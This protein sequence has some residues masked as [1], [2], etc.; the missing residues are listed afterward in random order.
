VK[1]TSKAKN[2]WQTRGYN[3]TDTENPRDF[4]PTPAHGTMALLRRETFSFSILEPASGNGAM[5]KVFRWWGH[6][7]EEA[8]LDR[9]EDFLRR[10]ES[11][12]SVVTNP[13]YGKGYAEKFVRQALKLA[14]LKV[15]MLLPF[16]FLEGVCRH[17]LFHRPDFPLKAV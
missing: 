6:E 3:R 10:K 16:Y 8:D 11:C 1:K 15:A 9:G 17:D 12:W 7:V 14:R 4:Y 13:P 5:A 2:Y